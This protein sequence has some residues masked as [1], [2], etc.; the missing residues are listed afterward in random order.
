MLPVKL[1]SIDILKG[2]DESIFEN[3]MKQ[4]PNKFYK[5]FLNIMPKCDA[6][7]SNVVETFNGFICE[8]RTKLLITMLEAI[9]ILLIERMYKKRGLVDNSDKQS[10]PRIMKKIKKRKMLTRFCIVKPVIEN[11]F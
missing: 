4:D 3:L 10:C 5:T 7:T 1:V 11:K 8:T 2:I 6:I 9:T